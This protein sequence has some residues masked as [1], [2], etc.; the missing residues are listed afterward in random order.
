MKTE[1]FNGLIDGMGV[2]RYAFTPP[3][4]S[5]TIN[6]EVCKPSYRPPEEDTQTIEN[7]FDKAVAHVRQEI[8]KQANEIR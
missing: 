7:D 8:A 2:S 4:V 3:E 1:F 5:T 6:S